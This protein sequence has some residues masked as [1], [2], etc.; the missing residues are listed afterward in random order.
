[1]STLAAAAQRRDAALVSNADFRQSP[2]ATSL[3]NWHAGLVQSIT[4]SGS[5]G[6]ILPNVNVSVVHTSQGD[7]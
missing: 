1:M 7:L 5:W 6:G 4:I 2:P 3:Q